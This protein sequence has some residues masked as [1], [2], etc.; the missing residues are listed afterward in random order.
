VITLIKATGKCPHCDVRKHQIDCT[1]ERAIQ[2]VSDAIEHHIREE[3][4]ELK[5]TQGGES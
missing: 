3:H 5:L 1:Q 2:V 4:P